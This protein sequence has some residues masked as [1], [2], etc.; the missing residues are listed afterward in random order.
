MNAVVTESV[1]ERYVQRVLEHIPRPLPARSRI[2]A[3]L[4]AH[5]GEAVSSGVGEAAAVARMGPPEEVARNYLAEARPPYA[6]LGQRLLAFA[7]DLGI[8]I[9]FLGFL[10]LMLGLNVAALGFAGGRDLVA[11]ITIPTLVLIGLAAFVLSIVY[12][13]VMETVF[14]QTIGK[15]MVGICVAKDDF[16]AVGALDAIVR[17]LPLFFEFWWLDA[18][19]AP[20]TEKRQRAFDLVAKTVVVR[21]D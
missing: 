14:A 17:R 11:L 16:T 19:V 7:V 8:G 21:C 3:D 1:S 10:L 9:V 5:L 2:E 12:F 20:F 13:P 4:R 6:S 18:L 15:R